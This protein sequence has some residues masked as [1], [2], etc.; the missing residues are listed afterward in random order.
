MIKYLLSPFTI[1]LFLLLL[2]A[3]LGLLRKY[4]PFKIVLAAAILFILLMSNPFIP[5]MMMRDL[6]TRYPRSLSVA[7][8]PKD[9]AYHILV[10][11]A[12]YSL[13]DGLPANDE[14]NPGALIRLSEG[15]RLYRQ[16]PG[17]KLITSGNSMSGRTPQAEVMAQAALLLGI[18]DTAMLKQPEPAITYEEAQTYKQKFASWKNPLILVTSAAHMP[19]AMMLFKSVGLKP[20]PAATAHLLKLGPH[21][22]AKLRFSLGNLKMAETAI[23]EYCGILYTRWFLFD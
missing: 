4:K 19:R 6:E 23:H 10:L 3:I 14:L 1:F 18:P 20:I 9:K 5:G 7:S 8:L 13:E 12:G 17:S 21:N 16:L 15:I 2:A 11:G 22:P